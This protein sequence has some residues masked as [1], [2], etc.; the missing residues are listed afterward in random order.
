LLNGL[1]KGNLNT[2]Y[3]V[4]IYIIDKRT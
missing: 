1:T 2:K 3:D 4:I